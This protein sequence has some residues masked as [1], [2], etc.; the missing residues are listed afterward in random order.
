MIS[1]HKSVLFTATAIL[2][3]SVFLHFHNALLYMPNHGFDGSGHVY[4]AQYIAQYGALPDPNHWET[5]QPPLYYVIGALFIRLASMNVKA[6]QFVNPILFFVLAGVAFLALKKTFGM[7]MPTCIGTFAV[8]ALPMLNI[9]PPMVT[10]ELLNALLITSSFTTALYLAYAQTKREIWL[11]I[12]L[13]IVITV[14]GFY[15]KISIFTA[16]P[17][18]IAALFLLL[19]NKEKLYSVW[20]WILICVASIALVVAV[21][22]PIYLRTPKTAST[23]IVSV[24]QMKVKRPAYFFYRMDWLWKVDMFNAQY[25]SFLGGSWNSFWQDGHNAITPFVSF[26]KKVLILW[27]LGFILLPISLYGWF[28][29]WKKQRKT[30]LVIGA[31]G[32]TALLIYIVFNIKDNHYSSVRLTY[33][34]PIAIV[35]AFGIAGASTNKKLRWL[36]TILLFIQYAVMVNH[37]WIQPWWHVTK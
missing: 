13:W 11:L 1:K 9:F 23:N 36:L 26:H 12:L 32:L 21:S 33:I 18:F 5:H 19:I 28:T 29:L 22:F 7:K 25:Y 17:S 4:Y 2:F 35:Y 6:L 14:L 31:Y 34:M 16:L 20:Q 8:I 27:S 15:T 3:I 37:F 24:A 30:A 10:N